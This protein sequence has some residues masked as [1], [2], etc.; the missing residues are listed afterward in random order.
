MKRFFLFVL[1]L[2]VST[3]LSLRC[4][5]QDKRDNT[6]VLSTWNIGHF[7]NGKKNYSQINGRS[8]QSK[9]KRFRDVMID[10]IRA[11]VMCLNEY[12][13]VFGVDNFQ[14]E[15]QS[16]KVLLNHFKKKKEGKL[17]GFSCNA[18][19]SNLKVKN[20]QE[21]LF[22]SSKPFIEETPRAA[23]YYYLSADL[24]VNEVLVKLICAHTTSGAKKICR[25]QIAELIKKYEQYDR[26]IMC[27]DWN[28]TDFSQFK[29]AGFAMANDGSVITFPSKSY[30]LD[31]IIVK[32]L[33]IENVRVIRTDLS[34]HYPLVCRLIV[35]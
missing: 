20:V 23:N 27:G 24:Y 21:H 5:S 26:V 17:A 31:N 25:T 30:A 7:A 1:F 18:I 34:D 3:V 13:H 16:K 12:S 29:K 19:F 35:Q 4:I 8:F 32:G 2:L 22:E 28:I 9:L 6:F 14:K 10:S 15:H 33:L 11:D